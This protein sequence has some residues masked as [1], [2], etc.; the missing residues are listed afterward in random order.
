MGDMVSPPD[1][2]PLAGEIYISGGDLPGDPLMVKG[3]L[4]PHFTDAELA[5][6]PKRRE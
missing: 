4:R 1:D 5:K 2:E 3:W 6:L